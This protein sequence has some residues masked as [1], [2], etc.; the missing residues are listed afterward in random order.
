M[1]LRFS[2]PRNPFEWL[3]AILIFGVVLALGFMLMGV[4]IVVV[5]VA[6]IAA[7]IVTWWRRKKGLGAMPRH[8]PAQDAPSQSPFPGPP[9][10]GPTPTSDEQDGPIVD[11]EFHVK[12]D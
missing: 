10:P 3:L 2:S 9:S 6:L 8:A 7:P 4:V 1:E 5:A 11:A 12:D